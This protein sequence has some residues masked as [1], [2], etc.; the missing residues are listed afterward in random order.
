VGATIRISPPHLQG[1]S[2][3]RL[4]FAGEIVDE[5]VEAEAAESPC[6]THPSNRARAPEDANCTSPL[7]QPGCVLLGEAVGTVPTTGGSVVG[8]GSH[9]IVMTTNTSGSDINL[10]ELGFPCGGPASTW[11]VWVGSA[12]P[13]DFSTPDFSGP[14]TPTDPDPATFPPTTY[15]YLDVT[16][17]NVLIPA[18]SDFW[19]GYENPGVGGQVDC[20][21][22][23]TY[24]WYG[25]AWDPDDTW[26]RTAVMQ[27]FGEL[28]PVELQSFS[29][30]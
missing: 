4:A 6:S 15:A 27:V 19:F 20:N 10:S 25:G 7:L 28:V 22:L 11:L 21:G 1:A 30:E 9:F 18:G 13:A 26:G 14:F 16:A 17:S 8:W 3:N 12:Q 24:A 5:E 23:V 2:H 29:V